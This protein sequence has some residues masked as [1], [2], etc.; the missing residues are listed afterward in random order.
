MLNMLMIA[1]DSEHP[2]EH[3][4]LCSKETAQTFVFYATKMLSSHLSYL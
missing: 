1:A 3:A 4:M 2:R